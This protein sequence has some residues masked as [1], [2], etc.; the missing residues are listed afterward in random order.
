MDRNPSTTSG[1]YSLRTDG[2]GAPM[3]HEKPTRRRDRANSHFCDAV[4]SRVFCP[5]ANCGYCGDRDGDRA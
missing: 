3:G 2:R 5:K 4:G 1:T